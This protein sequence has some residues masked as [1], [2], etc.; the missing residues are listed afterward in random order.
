MINECYITP[1]YIKS[2]MEEI[3][4][5]ILDKGIVDWSDL[6]TKYWLPLTYIKEVTSKSLSSLP[7]GVLLQSNA[8]VSHTFAER[9]SCKVRGIMRAIT[10]PVSMSTLSSRFQ[11]EE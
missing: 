9:L 2:M 4:D 7:K 3:S 11:I 8:I 1:K 10:R 6:T 5:L